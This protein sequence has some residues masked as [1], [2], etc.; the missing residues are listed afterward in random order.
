MGRKRRLILPILITLLMIGAI[1]W[2]AWLWYDANVDRSGW[3]T[4][5]GV[6][7]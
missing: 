6:R 7:L 1:V 2:G 4:R 5:D 3:A